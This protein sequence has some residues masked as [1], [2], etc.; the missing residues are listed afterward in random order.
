MSF[1]G[2]RLAWDRLAKTEL[3]VNFWQQWKWWR[4]HELSICGKTI[5]R[6]KTWKLLNWKF[7]FHRFLKRLN[8]GPLYFYRRWE[9][10]NFPY[11]WLIKSSKRN[12]RVELQHY[13]KVVVL[14]S[15]WVIFLRN[16]SMKKCSPLSKSVV[17]GILK[18]I[19]LKGSNGME[20]MCMRR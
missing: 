6:A 19:I 18:K 9:R 11:V 1:K 20:A 15:H 13:V 8:K 7:L 12:K 2:G 16:R 3:F 4:H 14:F 10:D 5:I 17:F